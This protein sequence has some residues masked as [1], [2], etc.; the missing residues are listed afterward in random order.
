MKVLILLNFFSLLLGGIKDEKSAKAALP[1]LQKL[2]K[3]KKSL[4]AE[5]I[6]LGLDP[7]A[8]KKEVKSSKKYDAAQMKIALKFSAIAGKP[9]ITAALSDL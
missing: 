3:A 5:V 6:K 1:K 4:D 9:E 8:F 7:V 2:V